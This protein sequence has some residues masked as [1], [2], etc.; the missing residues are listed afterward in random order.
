MGSNPS[1]ETTLPPTGL[2]GESTPQAASPGRPLLTP[3]PL[4]VT[5]DLDEGAGVESVI[6]MTGGTITTETS[7]GTRF[8]LTIPEHA[9]LSDQKVQMTPV[10][11]IDGLPLS[12]GLLAAVDLKPE[13]LLLFAPAT[14]TIEFQHDISPEEFLGFS[15][16]NEGEELFLYPTQVTG[17][18]VSIQLMHFTGYGGGNSSSQDASSMADYPPSSGEDQAMQAA[19]SAVAKSGGKIP[20]DE[21]QKIL[22]DWYRSTVEPNL[23]AAMTNDSDIEQPITEFLRWA[24]KVALCGLTD[25]FELEIENGK[26]WI[27][28]AIQNAIKQTSQR[29]S[30][31]GNPLEA[32]RLMRLAVMSRWLGEWAGP[33]S[34]EYT[35]KA[36]NELARCGRFELKFDSIIESEAGCQVN[37]ISQVRATVQLK[38]PEGIDAFVKFQYKGDGNLEYVDFSPPSGCPEQQNMIM[39]P[40]QSTGKTGSRFFVVAATLFN[41]NY[42]KEADSQ[43][44]NIVVIYDPGKPEETM[45]VQCPDAAEPAEVFKLMEDLGLGKMRMW[46]DGYWATHKDEILDMGGGEETYV[47]QDWD[48]NGGNLYARKLYQ[49]K[50]GETKLGISVIEDTTMDLFFKPK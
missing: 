31:Q 41:L 22:R 29:C 27:G 30:S 40:A 5:V 38:V 8:T 13:G 24:R 46:P 4:Q 47:A 17:S 11:S 36:F 34:A 42:H 14:L 20:T 15:Y 45:I 25:K 21:F 28:K 18:T 10:V 3:N 49:G 7:G 32:R 1:H 2:P 35:D 37:F 23:K 12:G 26:I 43:P 39:C 50:R 19:A 33:S 48:Y 16:L 6:P 44:P 9:L